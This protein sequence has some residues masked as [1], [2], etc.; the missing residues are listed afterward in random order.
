MKKKSSV[1]LGLEIFTLEWGS[2]SLT[3]EHDQIWVY[4]EEDEEQNEMILSTH[5]IAVNAL[6]ALGWFKEDDMGWS[7]FV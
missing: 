2:W 5:E 6:E 4:P 7:H 1:Q 3:A